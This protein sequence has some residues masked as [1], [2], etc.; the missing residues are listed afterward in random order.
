MASMRTFDSIAMLPLESCGMVSAPFHARSSEGASA[1]R[2]S[3]SVLLF[4]PFRLS[5]KERWL[6]RDNTELNLSSRAFD[7]L[8]ALITRAGSIVSAR[9]LFQIVWPDVVVE[10][11]NLRV[12]IVALRKALGDGANGMR[13]V[14]NVPGRGYMFVAPIRRVPAVIDIPASPQTQQRLPAIPQQLYGR[15]EAVEKLTSLVLAK[16]FVT[17]VGPGGVGKTVVSIAA[18]TMLRPTFGDGVYFV[19]LASSSDPTLA[20]AAFLSIATF[21]LDPIKTEDAILRV[22]SDKRILLIFDN[23]EHVVDS[24]AALATRIFYEAPLV[25]LLATSREALRAHGEYVEF[26]VPLSHSAS[27]LS[28]KDHSPAV[29]LF[30]ERAG[31][32]G[33]PTSF[34]DPEAAAV[35][36][37]C[38]RLDGLP[39]A[40]ELI[41]SRV[42][43][44]GLPGITELV[45]QDTFLSLTGRRGASLRHQTLKQLVEWSFNLLSDEEQ[46]LLMKLSSFAGVFTLDAVRSL[47]VQSEGETAKTAHIL[48]G[49][50]DKSLVQVSRSQSELYYK[51]LHITRV[52]CAQIMLEK[53]DGQ[54]RV[55]IQPPAS[56]RIGGVCVGTLPVPTSMKQNRAAS[57]CTAPDVR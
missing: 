43:T 33:G 20:L 24:V 45:E 57:L 19:D 3:D 26:L 23:C 54:L 17:V 48:A 7:I 21:P 32:G 1:D 42:G 36:E 28:R 31:A 52:Y 29:Q 39:I 38:R 18:A 47:Y 41:A 34:S 16:R 30:L 51:L 53:A 4:G 15:T 35:R 27:G 56:D 37:I 46:S 14:V 8:I 44:L 5:I 22:L 12:H 25:H 9:E 2:S 55:V 6:C 50:V 49:L 11:S 40:I 13:F 10:A